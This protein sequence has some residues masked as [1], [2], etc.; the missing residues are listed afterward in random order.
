M[1]GTSKTNTK[2]KKIRRKCKKN[3][4]KVIF[5]SLR[6]GKGRGKRGVPFRL[7]L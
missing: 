2:E 3:S 1:K 4:R 6:G 5:R 7:T